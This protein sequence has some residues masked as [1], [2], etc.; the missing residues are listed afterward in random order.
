MSTVQF[1]LP[2]VLPSKAALQDSM[3]GMTSSKQIR[4]TLSHSD[5]NSQATGIWSCTRHHA[6]RVSVGICTVTDVINHISIQDTDI[7]M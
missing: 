7:H 2:S 5:D 3:C 1:T 6:F 4:L